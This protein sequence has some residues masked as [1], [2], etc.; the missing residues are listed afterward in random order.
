MNSLK[1]KIWWLGL[2]V[3]LALGGIWVR[4]KRLNL[5]QARCSGASKLI[6]L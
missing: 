6:E 4:S 1:G 5:P 3:I 2:V